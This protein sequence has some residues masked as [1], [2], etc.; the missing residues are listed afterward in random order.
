[1]D[2]VSHFGRFAAS[3]ALPLFGGILRIAQLMAERRFESR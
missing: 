1:M 3:P 2:A